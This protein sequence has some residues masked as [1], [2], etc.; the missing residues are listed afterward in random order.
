MPDQ[1]IA[2]DNTAHRAGASKIITEAVFGVGLIVFFG[3][4]ILSLGAFL[5]GQYLMRSTTALKEQITK[6]EDDLRPDLLNQILS[7]DKKMASVRGVLA[8]HVISSNVF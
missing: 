1:F 2:A 5:Y 4:L 3:A 7:L 8:G 6:L